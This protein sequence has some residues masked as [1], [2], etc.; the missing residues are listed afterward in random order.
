MYR[1]GGAL[2]LL[3]LYV[4]SRPGD[5]GL[6]AGK[7]TEFSW[8][9]ARGV[10]SATGDPA[11]TENRTVQATGESPG[12]VSLVLILTGLLSPTAFGSSPILISLLPNFRS[13]LP[14]T[15]VFRVETFYEDIE[16]RLR[17]YAN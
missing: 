12:N 5:P 10:P 8:S 17:Y 7:R 11:Q 13:S 9:I 1:L 6:P 16:L 15:L 4:A 2:A 3:P 14:P